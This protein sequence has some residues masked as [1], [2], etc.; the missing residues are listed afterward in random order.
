MVKMVW[1]NHGKDWNAIWQVEGNPCLT[2]IEYK[3]YIT[4]A[5]QNCVY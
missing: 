4:S 5:L 2:D 1:S 3:L